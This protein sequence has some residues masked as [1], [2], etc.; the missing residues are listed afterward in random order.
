[1]GNLIRGPITW[2]F[3]GIGLSLVVLT[4]VVIWIVAIFLPFAPELKN[5]LQG[6]TLYEFV[7]KVGFWFAVLLS[8]AGISL[9]DKMT[10]DDNTT[11]INGLGAVIRFIGIISLIILV[12]RQI[13]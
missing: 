8:L 3:I 9:G 2:G 12:V 10:M 7:T 5:Q 1:M 11:G 13:V 6:I 4:G